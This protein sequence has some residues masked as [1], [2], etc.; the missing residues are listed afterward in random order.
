MHTP[1]S[2]EQARQLDSRDLLARFRKRFY[3][4]AGQ[5]YLGG[6]SLGLLSRD[7]EH[8]LLRVL[9]EWKTRAI[10][11][12]L[13]G[14][15]PWFS[16]PDALAARIAKLVGAQPDEVT[17]AN[18]TT[19]NLHQLLATLYRS[20][21]ARPRALIDAL[22]FPSDRYALRSHLRLRGLDPDAN[23]SVVEA[24]GAGLLE[25]SRIEEALA[26]PSVQLAVLPTVVHTSGQ[27]LDA[28]RLCR[29]ARSHG[30]VIGLDLS[31]SIGVL[32]HALDEWDADFAFW[33]HYQYINAGPGVIGGLY[34]SRR[35]FGSDGAVEAGLAKWWSGRKERMLDMMDEFTLGFGAAALQIGTPPV[36]SMAPLEGALGAVEEAGLNRIRTK[37]LALTE[38]LREAIEFELPNA[39][40]TFAT[41]LEPECRGGHLALLHG[42]AG[43]ICQALRRSGVVPDFRPPDLIRLAPA[44]LYTSFTECWDAVQILKRIMNYRSYEQASTVRELVT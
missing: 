20:Q 31:H 4:P 5:I 38:F 18:A 12:W 36:L 3:R 11:G 27:L 17:I 41:P 22:N 28:S 32:P 6:N 44:P 29:A 24:N 39:G 34:L 43:G 40:F 9:N 10:G 2:R 25:E 23:L 8:A 1:A 16:M 21:F 35:H 30:V 26:D 13:E 7:A 14:E 15:S 42:A 33:R 37:S 19:V